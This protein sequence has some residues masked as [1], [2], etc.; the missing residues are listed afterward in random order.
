MSSKSVKGNIETA[1]FGKPLLFRYTE[2]IGGV[3]KNLYTHC[4][5]FTG[6]SQN[7]CEALFTRLPLILLPEKSQVS[8][9]E[10]LSSMVLSSFMNVF[11]SLNSR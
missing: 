9:L 4:G 7:S 5:Q 2:Y 3:S 10:S 6:H 11:T 1:L 8:A